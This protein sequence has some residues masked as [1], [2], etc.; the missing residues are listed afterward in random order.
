MG[1]RVNGDNIPDGEDQSALILGIPGSRS[2]A[3][4]SSSLV[5]RGRRKRPGGNNP[6]GAPVLAQ[7]I[8]VASSRRARRYF[9]ALHIVALRESVYFSV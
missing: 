3:R 1:A 4:L 8:A 9:R 2:M 7:P 5:R 6:N